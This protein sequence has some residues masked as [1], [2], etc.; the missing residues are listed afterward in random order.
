MHGALGH[1][2]ARRTHRWVGR[3]ARRWAGRSLLGGHPSF[4]LNGCLMTKAPGRNTWTGVR[5]Y[6][7]VDVRLETR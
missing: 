4:F 7:L 3:E 1:T 5:E 2:L 6:G